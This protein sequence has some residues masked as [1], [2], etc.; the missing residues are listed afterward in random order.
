MKIVTTEVKTTYTI[1]L[2]FKDF[3]EIFSKA[4]SDPGRLD[5]EFSEFNLDDTSLGY[6]R[7]CFQKLNSNKNPKSI[8]YIVRKLGFAGIENYGL[9]NKRKGVYTLRV[10]DRGDTLNDNYNMQD[11]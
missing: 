3:A 8:E 6:M 9:F 11:T 5:A 2:Q 7:D 4:K 1:D 10:Y